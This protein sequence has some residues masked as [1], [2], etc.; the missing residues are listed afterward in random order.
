[1]LQFISFIHFHFN[2]AMTIFFMTSSILLNVFLPSPH[3]PLYANNVLC[4]LKIN[5][6]ALRSNDNPQPTTTTNDDKEMKLI[7][8]M[9]IT[10]IEFKL[11][12]KTLCSVKMKG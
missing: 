9:M 3:S 5:A 7:F 8:M 11:K 4:E 1:M 2:W 12:R 10:H 6:G